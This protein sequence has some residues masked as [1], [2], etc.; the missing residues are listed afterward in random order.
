MEVEDRRRHNSGT[1]TKKREPNYQRQVTHNQ[2]HQ[3]GSKALASRHRSLRAEE[4]NSSG[5]S[6]VLAPS[7]RNRERIYSDTSEPSPPRTNNLLLERGDADQRQTLA[8]TKEQ[9]KLLG[10]TKK[11]TQNSMTAEKPKGRKVD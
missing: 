10:P 1:C 11:L 5:Q 7:M 3:V 9:C 8:R 4:H 2:D 6:S